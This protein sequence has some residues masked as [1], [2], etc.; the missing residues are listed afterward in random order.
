MNF[1][2]RRFSYTAWQQLGHDSH[3]CPQQLV[4]IFKTRFIVFLPHIVIERHQGELR[5]KRRRDLPKVRDGIRGNDD[6]LV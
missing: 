1:E 2:R 4:V 5:P 6:L 3:D